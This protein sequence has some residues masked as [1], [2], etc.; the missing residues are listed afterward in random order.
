M[1]AHRGGLHT[2]P[3]ISCDFC[4]HRATQEH[5]W[6]TCTDIRRRITADRDWGW[7][8]LRTRGAPPADLCSADCRMRYL[9]PDV[10]THPL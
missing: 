3:S 7:T 2:Q 4:G 8:T 5:I 1:T 10:P 6:E 9:T